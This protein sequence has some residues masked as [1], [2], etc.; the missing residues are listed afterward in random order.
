[1]TERSGGD[2]VGGV[3]PAAEA[4]LEDGNVGVTLGEPEEGNSGEALEEAGRVR[5]GAL[6]DEAGG[7]VVD[8]EVEAGEV[9]V[10]DGMELDGAEGGGVVDGGVLGGDRRRGKLHALVD[11]NEVRRGVEGGTVAGGREDA[12]EGGGGGAFA[13]GASDEDGG[14]CVLGVAEGAHEGAHV[15]EIELAGG[16]AGGRG[17][18]AQVPRWARCARVSA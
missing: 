4:D 6:R 16:G 14:D 8:A 5:E 18:E 9:V 10:R 3:E 11:A 2:D 17:R 1:M 12:G 13:V 15:G 7:D